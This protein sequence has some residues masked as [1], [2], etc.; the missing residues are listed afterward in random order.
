MDEWNQ[1]LPDTPYERTCADLPAGQGA[2]PDAPV[3][4]YAS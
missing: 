3:A 4:E 2:P 1:F